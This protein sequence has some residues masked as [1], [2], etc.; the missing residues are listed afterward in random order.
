M[1]KTRLLFLNR[2]QRVCKL[3]N[4]EE[5]VID[6]QKTERSK[7][8]KCMGVLHGR[9]RSQVCGSSVLVDGPS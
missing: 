3:E 7:M 9:N 2:K 6:G 4:V 1:K 5:R 8:V